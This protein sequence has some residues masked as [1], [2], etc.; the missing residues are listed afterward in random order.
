MLGPAGNDEAGP[1]LEFGPPN[2]H[3]LRE[4]KRPYLL[5]QDFRVEERFGFDSHLPGRRLCRNRGK[6]KRIEHP[7]SNIQH[8]KPGNR[9][10]PTKATPPSC[11]PHA[12]LKPLQS[13]GKAPGQPGATQACG[14]C[15]KSNAR[16]IGQK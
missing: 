10:K 15:F 13:Q 5:A 8:P 16:S 7:T 14:C 12:T 6:T 4:V 3:L 9:A 2:A 1:V 11:D